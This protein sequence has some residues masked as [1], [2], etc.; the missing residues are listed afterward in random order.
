MNLYRI[1][2]TAVALL[3]LSACQQQA[4]TAPAPPVAATPTMPAPAPVADARAVITDYMTAWN[5]HD[6]DKAGSYFAEDGVYLDAS[7]GTPIFP[8]SAVKAS[9][10]AHT[11]CRSPLAVCSSK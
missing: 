1:T 4:A 10:D 7:V 6:G 2:L 9:T 8:V 3:A 11:Y 5:A